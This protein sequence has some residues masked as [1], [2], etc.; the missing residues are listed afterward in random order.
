VA[1]QTL[2]KMAVLWALEERVR[3]KPAMTRMKARQEKSAAVV[4]MLFTL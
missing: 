4:S 2:V 1:T 3:G